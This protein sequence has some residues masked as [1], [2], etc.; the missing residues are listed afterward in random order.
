MDI[1]KNNIKYLDIL[2]KYLYSIDPNENYPD[3]SIKEI[4]ILFENNKYNG[5]PFDYSDIFKHYG[6]IF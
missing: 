1:I 6:K 3:L 4:K 5:Y 2:L